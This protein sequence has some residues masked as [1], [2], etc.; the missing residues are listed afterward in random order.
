LL[1][2]DSRKRGISS[3]LTKLIG[4][5]S[6]ID[7]IIKH[8]AIGGAISA[9]TSFGGKEGLNGIFSREAEAAQLDARAVSLGALGKELAKGLGSGALLSGVLGVLGLATGGDKQARDIIEEHMFKARS[10][11]DADVLEERMFT[12]RSSVDARAVSL[13]A[14]G[15]ELAK[16]LGSGA[17]LSGVLGLATGGDKQARDLSLDERAFTADILEPIIGSVLVSLLV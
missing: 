5:A 11:M 14:L 8:S 12:A 16:G 7:D 3:A 9:A 6:P 4:D 15:K 17:L 1:I 10:S 2:I 13:G